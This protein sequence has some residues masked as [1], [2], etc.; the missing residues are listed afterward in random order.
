[1]K[2]YDPGSSVISLSDSD[3]DAP[4]SART[5]SQLAPTPPLTQLTEYDIVEI[6]SDEDDD[7]ATIPLSSQSVEPLSEC[8]AFNLCDSSGDEASPSN[9]PSATS[10]TTRTSSLF[11]SDDD[12]LPPMSAII[13]S[14]SYR[15][16]S[17]NK[18][19]LSEA[20]MPELDSDST[21]SPAKKSRNILNERSSDYVTFSCF[22]ALALSYVLA[23]RFI[24]FAEVEV[25]IEET[26]TEDD[27]RARERKGKSP[28]LFSSTK[29]PI[30]LAAILERQDGSQ[31]AEE[32]TTPNCRS[33][34][35]GEERTRAPSEG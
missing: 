9:H 7:S 19:R 16:S 26:H 28:L 20:S 33:S 3:D 15:P 13:A 32:S 5:A 12:D 25:E 27:S 31:R 24:C 18:R 29:I 34:Q 8:E 14:I 1:M 2:Y 22:Q 30:F 6:S 10:T 4:R 11:D 17:S 35:D 21:P 23:G